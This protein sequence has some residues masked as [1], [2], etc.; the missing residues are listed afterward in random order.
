M[1]SRFAPHSSSL[2]DPEG[3]RE[4]G[5]AE[6]AHAT[7]V[8]PHQRDDIAHVAVAL[9]AARRHLRRVRVDRVRADA[10][11]GAQ[12]GADVAGE[13][14]VGGAV[15]VEVADLAAADGEGELAATAGAGFDAGPGRDL[16][17]DALARS[18]VLG[19]GASSSLGGSVDAPQATSSSKL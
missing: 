13:A 15:A 10:A 14:E 4:L 19:H 16:A 9:D 1:S 17:G 18:L 5:R 12:L 7:V 3:G 8:Q 2:A 6:R 11:P